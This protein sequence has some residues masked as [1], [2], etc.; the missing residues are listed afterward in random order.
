MSSKP[1][2]VE[3]N[4]SRR[5]LQHFGLGCLGRLVVFSADNEPD[6]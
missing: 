4:L 6:V 2:E 3:R 5:L 1:R